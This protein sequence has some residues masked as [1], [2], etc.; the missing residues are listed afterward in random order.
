MSTKSSAVIMIIYIFVRQ[1]EVAS[2][3]KKPR[4]GDALGMVHV[5]GTRSGYNLPGV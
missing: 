4:E 3:R 5:V 2:D 1:D